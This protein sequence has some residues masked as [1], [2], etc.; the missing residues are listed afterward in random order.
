MKGLVTGLT[1][2]IMVGFVDLIDNKFAS[3]GF[4][5]H[6]KTSMVDVDLEKIPCKIREG[7]TL[8]AWEVKGVRVYLCGLKLELNNKKGEKR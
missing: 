1:F 4:T 5:R 2:L 8:I 6:G 3:V 7:D